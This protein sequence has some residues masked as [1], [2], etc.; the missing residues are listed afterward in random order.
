[1]KRAYIFLAD[2]FEDIEAVATADVLTRGGVK[3][4]FVSVSGSKSVRSSHGLSIGAEKSLD[5]VHADNKDFLIFPGGM[6]GAKNLADCDGL[7]QLMRSHFEDG[8]SLAAICAAP[9]VVL[10]KL[11]NL[12]AGTEFTCYDG[13][14]DGLERLGG[15]FRALPAVQSGR[16]VTGRGPGHAV[17]FGLAILAGIKGDEAAQAVRDGM[18]LNTED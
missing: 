9:G 12:P 13:F 8:G 15:H 11:G 7:M 17:E 3:T 5:E 1:M 18:I 14:E 16:I 10:G 6:P 4:E 2:G